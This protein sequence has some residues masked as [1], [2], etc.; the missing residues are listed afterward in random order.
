M[1]LSP[2]LATTRPATLAE[3]TAGQRRRMQR[4]V[5][6]F[7]QLRTDYG[8]SEQAAIACLTD[9]PAEASTN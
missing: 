8:L 9:L 1:N 2:S 6:M 5:S 4:A 3:P 7:H